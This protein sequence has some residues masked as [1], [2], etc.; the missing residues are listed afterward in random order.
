MVCQSRNNRTDRQ[1]NINHI[2]WIFWL[3]SFF[4]S[5]CCRFACVSLFN[6]PHNIQAPFASFI[7]RRSGEKANEN[8]ALSTRL[9]SIHLYL[10]LSQCHLMLFVR[11][12]QHLTSSKSTIDAIRL[13]RFFVSLQ[14]L[15]FWQTNR[16]KL[17]CSN[18]GIRRK[19]S[20]RPTLRND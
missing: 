10:L 7:N 18:N 3:W 11:L 9:I 5:G 16:R 13:A 14:T 15:N 1:L 12:V 8:F 19:S 20:T 17:W 4:D 2:D 6:I